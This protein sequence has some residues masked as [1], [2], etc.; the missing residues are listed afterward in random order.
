MKKK[1][2]SMLLMAALTAGTL[3]GCGDSG[4]K[5][6]SSSQKT[7]SE[8]NSGDESTEE[9]KVINV[10]SWNDEFSK[11]VIAVYPE[12]KETSKDGT[13]TT[14]KDGTEIHWIINPNQ[15]GVYQQKLDEALLNQASAAADDKVDIFL[16][17]TDYVNKYTDADAG[18]AMPLTDLGIDPDADLSD[19]YDFTKVTASD[20]NG[21]QRGSTWQ[22]CPG[23][24]VYRRDI[25]KE[26]FGTDDPVKVGEKVKDW[27]TM[28]KTA[29]ELKAKGYYTFSSY[30]DTFRLYGNSISEPW[31]KPG[32]TV[33]KVDQKIMDWVSTSKEWLDA[34]YLD[35]TV[36]GQ[37]NDDWNKAMGSKSKVFAFLFPAWGIDFTLKPNWDGG[38]GAWA[39]TNPPQEYNWGGSYVHACTGTDN[40]KHVK[41]IILAVTGDKDNLLKI[42][43]DYLDFTNTKSGMKEAA[44]DN[45]TFASEFLGGQNSFE[46]FTPVAENIVIAPLSPYDQGCVELIQ[47]S[48]SDY[49]QGQVDFD[50]AKSNFETAIKER[51][52]ETT[53]VQWP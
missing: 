35:K 33:I 48:F 11:R 44:E 14:L 46:Y 37:W 10:Y 15:D 49:F 23:L 7:S 43:K 3:T 4:N 1:Y 5:D 6:S 21:V 13:V 27:D 41:D 47:N 22:C 51:Y 20:V 34:G 40:P 12:V 36:K 28:A 8:N 45:K 24:L 25:A 38:D 18:V 16:S 32:E 50:K 30:A 26:V 52:P 39:V 53:E 2:I 31:V 42:S 29:E 17:E 19:Q 9:G